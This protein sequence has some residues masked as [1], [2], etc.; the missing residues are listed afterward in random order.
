MNVL[1]L[2]G[3][4]TFLASAAVARADAL[5]E[6]SEDFEC[7]DGYQIRNSHGGPS[8]ERPHCMQDSDCEDGTPCVRR[9]TEIIRPAGCE[10]HVRR[11][12]LQRSARAGAGEPPGPCD[13][14]SADRGE[15]LPPDWT[16]A[17]GSCAGGQCAAPGTPPRQGRQ[18]LGEEAARG[19]SLSGDEDEGGGA[20]PSA[21]GGGCCGST[22]SRT[23]ASLA[24]L[25]IAALALVLARRRR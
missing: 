7:P 14:Y 10:E 17:V 21:S 9:C 3:A 18:P 4:V 13:G 8:C 6:V 20:P 11:P 12:A 1:S 24:A 2:A 5:P 22:S 16:C 19:T 23:T 25:P 15:C